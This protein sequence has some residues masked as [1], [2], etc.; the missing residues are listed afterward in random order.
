[1]YSFQNAKN[2]DPA[3]KE[4]YDSSYQKDTS[5][6]EIRNQDEIVSPVKTNLNGQ[7]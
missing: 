4:K 7:S 2:E 1:M 5:K 3:N 6:N